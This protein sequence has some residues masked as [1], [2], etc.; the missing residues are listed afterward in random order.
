MSNL[1]TRI[2]TAVTGIIVVV[3]SAYLGPWP[4]GVV[5]LCFA[6]LAQ[7]ELYNIYARAGVE[8]WRVAGLAIGACLA[9]RALMPESL[10]LCVIPVVALV[11]W[12]PF[13]K[14]EQPLARLGATLAGAIY[15]AALLAFLTDIR[16]APGFSDSDAF[17]VTVTVLVLV[18]ATDTAAGFVGSLLGK[19]ALAP[20]VSPGKTWEGFYGGVAG[21]IIAAAVLR[22]TL[23]DA[24]SW[25]DVVLLALICSVSSAVGDLAESR[26]KRDV[27]IKDSGWIVPGH[28]GVLDRFDGLIVAAPLA[29]L[30]LLTMARSS[31]I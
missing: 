21:A 23:A 25:V 12:C 20:S 16:M 19:H 4:F 5:I 6:L 14:S 15:P 7:N 18:W 24:L 27:S 26:F 17:A 10:L 31:F 29:Y 2:V 22:L 8:V 9:L 1:P 11:L 13:T 3:G 30:Y 28:G